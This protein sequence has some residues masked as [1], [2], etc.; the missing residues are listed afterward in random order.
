MVLNLILPAL[1]Q[2][3]T[4][5]HTHDSG[6]ICENKDT[7][8]FQEGCKLDSGVKSDIDIMEIETQAT[9]GIQNQE[10]MELDKVNGPAESPPL[11]TF[12]NTDIW[13]FAARNGGRTESRK[14]N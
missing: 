4:R 7:Q 1:L 3:A 14:N 10:T 2:E 13:S 11:I 5:K 12:P 8:M 6:S 9:E